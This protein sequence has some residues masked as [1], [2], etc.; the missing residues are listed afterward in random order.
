MSAIIP[1]APPRSPAPVAI[2]GVGGSGTRLIAQLLAAAGFRIGGDRNAADDNLW[3]TLLFKWRGVLALPD[4]DFGRL[5]RLFAAVMTG[6]REIDAAAITMARDLAANARAQ[7]SR[8][9]LQARLASLLEALAAP[10][11]AAGRWGWKEPNTHVVL[12]RLLPH[13]PG[14]RYIHVMRNGLDMAWSRNQNQLALWGEA[15]LG[16]AVTVTPRDSL[17]YWCAVHRRVA[18]LGEALGPR[19]LLLDY[20][21]FCRAP[22]A[23]VR[24]LLAFLGVPPEAGRVAAL[25]RA[26]RPPASI[27]RHALH[28]DAGFDAAD[29]ACV[30]DFGFAVAEPLPGG[31]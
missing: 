24:R 21:A 29:V 12:D 15:F 4:A 18:T 13:F 22:E 1:P 25:A 31:R 19:F 30:R 5:C 7:H 27:G 10:A 23:G 28:P 20:D 6:V 11:P 8:P 9:W 16:R 3:F 17:A 14:L 26:V 2:G